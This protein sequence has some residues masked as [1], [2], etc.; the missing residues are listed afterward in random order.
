MF[1]RKWLGYKQVQVMQN[2]HKPYNSSL[3]KFH[4][5]FFLLNMLAEQKWLPSTPFISSQIPILQDQLNG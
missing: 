4:Q 5:L 1:S 2:S 3:K